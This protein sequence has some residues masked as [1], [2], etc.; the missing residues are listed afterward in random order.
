M[1][2]TWLSFYGN[3]VQ[4]LGARGT[5]ANIAVDIHGQPLPPEEAAWYERAV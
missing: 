2:A 5:E 4:S 1:P 3:Y